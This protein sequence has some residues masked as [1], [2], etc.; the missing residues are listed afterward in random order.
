[1]ADPAP[2]EA[3][4]AYVDAP[5]EDDAF[6]ETCYARAEKLVAKEIADGGVTEADIVAGAIDAEI[7]D[8][9]IIDVGAELYQRRNAPFGVTTFATGE[10]AVGMRVSADPMVRARTMLAP[11]LKAGFA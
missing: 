11:Y 8:G 7:I 10:G 3:L 1:M 2:W 4:K 6:V 9:A 5:T